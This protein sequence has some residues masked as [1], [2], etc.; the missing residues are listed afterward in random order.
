VK[1]EKIKKSIRFK[2][3]NT[4]KASQASYTFSIAGDDVRDCLLRWE[5]NHLGALRVTALS[6]ENT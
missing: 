1:L 6:S 3:T 2:I 4:P 5:K